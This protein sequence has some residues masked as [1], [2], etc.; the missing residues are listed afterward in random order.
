M[1]ALQ[2]HWVFVF[3]VVKPYIE[4]MC[5]VEKWQ[6]LNSRFLPLNFPSF[7]PFFLNG[8]FSWLVNLV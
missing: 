3:K 4:M 7:S 6:Y 5:P 8:V 2:Y 1:D